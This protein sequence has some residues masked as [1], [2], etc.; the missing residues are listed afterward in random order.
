M[1]TEQLASFVVK[2]KYLF[3]LLPI[4][5]SIASFYFIKDI[6]VVTRSTDFMPTNHPFVKV[7]RELN[8]HFGGL[9]RVNIAIEVDKGTILNPIT[10]E[11]L[12]GIFDEISYLDEINPRR[13]LCLFSRQIKHIEIHKDG[14]EVRRLLRNVPQTKEQWQALK[15][16]I[17]RNPLVYG[18]LVSKDLKATLIQ[19]EF[20]E[21]V[22][23]RVIYKKV[24]E[25]I[26]KYKDRNHHIYVSGRPILEGYI[27]THSH[28]IL[29]IFAISLIITL[30][31]LFLAF[32]K[33]KRAIV[34]PAF[35]ATM[36]V[37]I[38]LSIFSFFNYPINPF[39]ILI[40]FMVFIVTL[41]HS[42]Q[43]MQR[44][45]EASKRYKNKEEVAKEVLAGLSNP[46]R[47]SIFTDFLGFASLFLIPIPSIRGIAILGASGIL[48]LF[49]TLVGFM[50]ACF[51]IFPL[52][53]FEKNEFGRGFTYK[54]LE[55]L[56]GIYT[57]KRNIAV[58]MCSFIAISI[59]SIYGIRHITVGEI[60]P[61]TSILYRDAPYN[62]AE[63]KINHYFSGSNPYYIL[64]K[65][66]KENALVRADV[67][68][69]MDG[70][71]TYLRENS[72]AAGYS[73]SL[74]DYIK[75]MNFVVFGGDRRYFCVPESD[76]A[77]GEYLFLYE[78]NAFPGE[79]SGLFDYSHRYA[80]IRLDLKDCKGSTI[81]EIISETK[82]WIKKHH[83]TPWVEFE[84]A[85][86]PIGILGAT[87][88]IMKEGLLLNM[89]VLS[90]LIIL[91]V[92]LALR[93]I[94]GGLL[95][96]IPLLFS[97]ILTFGSFG[98]LN[99]PFTLSTLPV[100]A[101]GAGL[102][103]DYSIYLASRIKEETKNGKSLDKAI[104][105]AVTTCGMAVLFVGTILSIGSF[106][107]IFSN[108]KLQA[109]LGGV[110]AYLK[111]L[112]MLSALILLPTFLLLIK[113]KF[114]FK[115]EEK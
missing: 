51:A 64:V 52:P 41:N 105:Y 69:E 98:I 30:I 106:S 104:F 79:F 73:L 78:N 19:A 16:R 102:G 22:P 93:S 92:C 45:F 85:G 90:I 54:F 103:I 18:P 56:A 91:R 77:I 86:G 24:N 100:A 42:V 83:K 28:F 46:V 1:K 5:L 13:I 6:K 8:K 110:F 58:I 31:L 112:N 99:I 15:Q 111:F 107:W 34:L 26:K 113:P 61:G 55:R 43:F 39:T 95:L 57:K 59:L 32:N 101:M 48:S 115:E 7:Q 53:K 35:S 62:I 4:I 75:L 47:A 71:E 17:I 44:Y 89:A 21:D 40:P 82:N 97:I 3:L 23:S 67:M 74:A 94:V 14:F 25:I 20:K 33:K 87:N 29:Y 81:E 80:N 66:K 114:L 88:E 96:F 109:K 37:V 12:Y 11:K 36:S 38:A 2:H 60:E 70:L 27:E 76:K 49:L 72:T 108:L 10:L 84:F 63:R 9:N 65:G 50:P 68:K